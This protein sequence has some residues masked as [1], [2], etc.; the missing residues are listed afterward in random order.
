VLR[1]LKEKIMYT[2]KTQSFTTFSKEIYTEHIEEASFLYE[3]RLTLF[4]DRE[5]VWYE[6]DDFEKRLES[7]IYAL[8]LGGDSAR[9]VCQEEAI[10]GDS[11]EIYTALCV[12]CRQ[13]RPDLLYAVIKEI[14]AADADIVAAVSDA[15]CQEAPE[16]WFD[17]ITDFNTYDVMYD[18]RE[19]ISNA[20]GYKKL[21]KYESFIIHLFNE[22]KNDTVL[23]SLIWTIGQ[24]RIRSLIKP[25]TTIYKNFNSHTTRKAAL[26]A[27]LT[28]R[29][30]TSAVSLLLADNES[31]H[32]YLGHVPSSRVSR[33][34]VQLL[35]SK[36]V[37]KDIII[38]A[39]ISGQTDTI[40]LLLKHLENNDI[41][42]EAAMS[43]FL[44]TG[45]P[46]FEDFAIPEE[47]DEDELFDDEIDKSIKGEII[48]KDGK[49]SDIT[50][51]RISQNRKTWVNWFET[52][53]VKFQSLTK[54]RLGKSLSVESAIDS[55]LVKSIPN[56]IRQLIYDSLSIHY[57]INTSFSYTMNVKKQMEQ[58][59]KM[60]SEVN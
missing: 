43:L 14:N 20:I 40:P 47:I 18:F 31:N 37:N 12:F 57:K 36:D 60:K 52:N 35:A 34:I 42:Y 41:A 56:R 59:K 9:K 13:D 25:L 53:E 54:A 19:A 50:I 11:G 48:F 5:L 28:I 44:I 4:N 10:E 21:S 17:K 33:K 27:L 3:Q 1:Q 49:T 32:R 26:L 16:H 23:N 22:E 8:A 55:M 2:I 7:H 15:L 45:A 29:S 58:I 39:G 30:K 24:L 51:K 6:L 46:L 38:A